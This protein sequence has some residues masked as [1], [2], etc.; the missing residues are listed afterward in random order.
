LQGIAKVT[1]LD[2][3]ATLSA[4]LLLNSDNFSELLDFS[5]D[6]DFTE[7]DEDSI[8]L[9]LD[10]PDFSLELDFL[11]SPWVTLDEDSAFS[12][13]DEPSSAEDDVSIPGSSFCPAEADDES[14]HA[15]RNANNTREIATHFV[16]AMTCW[17]DPITAPLD[18]LRDQRLQDDRSGNFFIKAF[19]QCLSKENV[20]YFHPKK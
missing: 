16:L 8:T 4:E 15:A 7:L 2:E 14:S 10:F 5:V 19:K 3:D 11:T 1:T 20:I 9:L 13:L 12:L 6:S 17:M 18:K